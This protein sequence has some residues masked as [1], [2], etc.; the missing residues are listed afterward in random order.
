MRDRQY[1]LLALSR[2]G[3][4]YCICPLITQNGH[5]QAPTNLHL[6]VRE[7]LLGSHP[8]SRALRELGIKLARLF[9]TEHVKRLYELADTID[10][11]AE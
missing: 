3:L 5:F 9:P 1:P 2:H 11:S 6:L 10:L 7:C 4:V 8:R